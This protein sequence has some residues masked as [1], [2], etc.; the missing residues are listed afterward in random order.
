ML[1]RFLVSLAAAVVVAFAGTAALGAAIA[2]APLKIIATVVAH[3][4]AISS[5][6]ARS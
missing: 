3:P 4:H 1:A 2:P 5:N 6:V